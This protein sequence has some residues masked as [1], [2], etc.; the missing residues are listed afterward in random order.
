MPY[1]SLRKLNTIMMKPQRVGPYQPSVSHLK[2][3]RVV[4]KNQSLDALLTATGVAFLAA[5]FAVNWA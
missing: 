1:P 4:P 5:A 3:H 2:Q